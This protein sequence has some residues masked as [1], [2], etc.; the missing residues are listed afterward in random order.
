MAKKY[1]FIFLFDVICVITVKLAKISGKLIF[2]YVHIG[3]F[4]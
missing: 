4:F 1:I 2:L 3:L